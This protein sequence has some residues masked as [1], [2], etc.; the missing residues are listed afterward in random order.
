MDLFCI[1]ILMKDKNVNKILSLFNSVEP[2]KTDTIKKAEKNHD[3]NIE[4]G[5]SDEKTIK[6]AKKLS[7][8]IDK[9]RTIEALKKQTLNKII[10]RLPEINEQFHIVSNGS[11][12]YFN[13]IPRILE[14]TDQKLNLYCSTW[15]MNYNNVEKL[16]QL[17]DLKRINPATVLIGEYLQK[18]EPLVYTELANGL[19]ERKGRV[20]AFNNHC[21]II[22][23]WNDNYNFVLEGSANF[24]ANPR[25]EQNIFLN[26]KEVLNFHKN[27][28]SELFND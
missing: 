19:H 26:S 20:K 11:F 21:K 24:T 2:Y 27:W 18:R 12:D 28:I 7:I 8:T 14:L 13:M 23:L 15:T 5:L 10:D 17:I 6:S 3:D 4:T 22:L 16:M 1:F 25:V 9:K